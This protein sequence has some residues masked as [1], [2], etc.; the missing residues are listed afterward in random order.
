[1]KTN[2]YTNVLVPLDGS[3][4]SDEALEL[5]VSVAFHAGATLHLVH[6]QDTPDKRDAAAE[7]REYLATAT[8]RAAQTLNQKDRVRAP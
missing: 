8:K 4:V 3:A 1:M 7:A 2:N 6:V 5:A